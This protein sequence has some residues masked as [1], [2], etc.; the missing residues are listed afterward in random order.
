[1]GHVLALIESG[2]N[3]DETMSNPAA[4]I[5][6]YYNKCDCAFDSEIMGAVMA[7]TELSYE[8]ENDE[9]S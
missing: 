3:T 8:N 4:D 5:E 1:M 2:H 7:Q 9:V 6:K